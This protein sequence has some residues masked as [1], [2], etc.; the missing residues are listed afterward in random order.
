M[1]TWGTFNLAEL[2]RNILD[3]NLRIILSCAVLDADKMIPYQDQELFLIT[4]VVYS[5]KFEVVGK[6]KQEVCTFSTFTLDDFPAFVSIFI[7]A[8]FFQLKWLACSRF[9]GELA[10]Y[11]FFTSFGFQW[12]IKAGLEPPWRFSKVLKSDSR[13]NTKKRQP[14]PGWQKEVRGDQF[15]LSTVVFSIT[16]KQ[17]NWSS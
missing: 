4:S 2:A 3:P 9:S 17:K 12:E 6:R 16:R 13:V 5:E 10:F 1:T 14:L 15:F 8:D 7:S 11:Q